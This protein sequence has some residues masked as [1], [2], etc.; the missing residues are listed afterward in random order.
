MTFA[1]VTPCYRQEYKHTFWKE[2]TK[3]KWNQYI[4]CLILKMNSEVQVQ[5][6]IF[7]CSQNHSGSESTQQ[8]PPYAHKDVS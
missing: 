5:A 3:Y 6:S 1:D 8:V 2:T 4:K 7:F